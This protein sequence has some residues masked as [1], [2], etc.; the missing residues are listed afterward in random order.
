MALGMIA[1]QKLGEA[2][3]TINNLAQD[4]RPFVIRCIYCNTACVSVGP[5]QTF[6]FI[7]LAYDMSL[8]V[9]VCMNCLKKKL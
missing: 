9:C 7:A 6:A 4:R 3:N 8:N 1:Q 5:E 2:M